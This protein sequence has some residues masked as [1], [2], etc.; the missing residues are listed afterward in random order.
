MNHTLVV[1]GLCGSLIGA[2]GC[3]GEDETPTSGTGGSGATGG[4]GGSGATAGAGGTGGTGGTGG[5][6]VVDTDCIIEGTTYYLD[7][8]DGLDS[9]DGSSDQPW[10][11]LAHAQATLQD[12]DGVLLRDG[13]Y[14]GF[15]HDGTDHSDWV[16]YRADD[17]HSP[18]LTGI[19]VDNSESADA[20][21]RFCGLTVQRPEPDPWPVDDGQRHNLGRVVQIDQ[22]HHIEL[23][24]CTLKGINKYL[25]GGVRL[26]HSDNV[27]IAGC[28]ISVVVGGVHATTC[29]DFVLSYNHVHSMAEGSGIRFQGNVTGT[30]IEGN[31]VHGQHGN[32]SEPY[33]P[34]NDQNDWHPG[35]GISIRIS[36]AVIRNNIIHDG[37]SQGM[38]FYIDGAPDEL[39]QNMLVENNLFY[40]TGRVALYQ[41]GTDILVRN[42]TFVSEVR[43]DGT[44]KYDILQRYSQGAFLMMNFAAGHDGTGVAL[45]NNLFV[46]SWS[47]PGA[48]APY[49]EDYNFFWLRESGGD[50]LESGKGAHTRMAVWRDD[51]TP[52]TLRG[53]PN[54]FED[55][56]FTGDTPEYSFAQ[57]GI[58]PFFVNA[59]L[60]TG[61]TGG[62]Q[63]AG[64]I[65]DYDLASGSP[66]S[67]AGDSSRQPTDSLGSLDAQGFIQ[68]DGPAR[69]AD[70]HSM[71]AYE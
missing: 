11:T 64:Q 12:G 22:A 32:A 20:Y 27:T 6:T 68:R 65:W 42:N 17:G 38:M 39:Y 71:G 3:S 34:S 53:N 23:L 46:G 9:G 54:F 63:D 40:D 67:N 29:N 36:N 31:H 47:L 16:T 62:Y 19:T 58:Q 41:C 66:A 21:L 35:S 48:S 70:H 5:G 33:F 37:F 59:G 51:A 4:T 69:D 43:V 61:E 57:D 60:Y 44:G 55:M 7:A 15:S 8:V 1:L 24:D 45:V 50:Y 2:V 49:E 28:D 56:G 18:V 10:Q 52:Y 25:S 30:I 26:N 14:G 13:D